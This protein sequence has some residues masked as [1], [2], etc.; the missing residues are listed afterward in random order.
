MFP[1]LLLEKRG[2]S[3]DQHWE[4]R[5]G[6]TLAAQ[7]QDTQIFSRRYPITHGLSASMSEYLFAKAC[8]LSLWTGRQTM[9]Y[10]SLNSLNTYHK[11][12]D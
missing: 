11:A 3:F 4:G 10:L 7:C 1:I 2:P 6:R 12:E 8:G 5:V 9:L